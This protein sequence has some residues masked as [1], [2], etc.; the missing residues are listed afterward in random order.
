MLS[1][2]VWN[3]P[4]LSALVGELARRKSLAL[5][6]NISLSEFAA[7]C[8]KFSTCTVEITLYA[9]KEQKLLARF[10]RTI[11]KSFFSNWSATC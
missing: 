6:Y 8:C 5:H 4:L 9:L 11:R 2:S 10:N 7:G 3:L 1:Q